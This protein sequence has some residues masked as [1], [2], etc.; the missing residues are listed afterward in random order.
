MFNKIATLTFQTW[1]TKQH[2]PLQWVV[3]RGKLHTNLQINRCLGYDRL[4]SNVLI[5]QPR[6]LANQ[7]IIYLKPVSEKDKLT[8]NLYANQLLD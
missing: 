1:Q 2:C 8:N 3:G 7:A 6:D 5:N 4:S